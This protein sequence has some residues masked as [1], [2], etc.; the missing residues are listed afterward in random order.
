MKILQR[1]GVSGRLISSFAAIGVTLAAICVTI[2]VQGQE[3]KTSIDEITDYRVPVTIHLSNLAKQIHVSMADTQATVLSGDSSHNEHRVAVWKAISASAAGLDRLAP[4]FRHQD[5]AASWRAIRSDLDQLK[6]VQEK[7]AAIVGTVEAM[8]ANRMLND[9]LEPRLQ[10]HF[11]EATALMEAETK[12][13]D[14]TALHLRY[15]ADL[16]A[17]TAGA[18][19][20][21]RG[22]LV[23]ASPKGLK[24]FEDSWAAATRGREALEAA[25]GGLVED[26]R[27]RLPAITSLRAEMR[28]RADAI[29]AIRQSDGWNIPLQ[30]LSKEAVPLADKILNRLEGNGTGI[31]PLQ[32]ERLNASAVAIQGKWDFMARVVFA[33]LLCSLVLSLVIALL[34]TRAIVAPLAR[35]KTVFGDLS[36]GRLDITIA[37]RE[38]QDEM[39]VMARALEVFRSRLKEQ[40]LAQDQ[41]HQQAQSERAQR[42]ERLTTDFDR[43][44]SQ[45]VETVTI[46]AKQLEGTADGLSAA[47]TQTDREASNVGMVSEQASANVRAIA[48]AASELHSSISEIGHQVSTASRISENAALQAGR[49]SEVAGKL[50]LAVQKIGD[51]SNLI[52]GIAA[53]TNL[54]AL[55]ATIEAARAGEAG[56]GFA[57][58]AS[59]VKGLANQTG[60]ATGEIAKQIADV[61]EQTNIVVEAIHSIGK[62]I[63]E[64]GMISAGIS[65]AV[66]KQSS[67]TSKI[68]HN[69][70]QATAGTTE[71]SRNI[72]G[73]QQAA[74][75][76]GSASGE[77]L[78]ASKVLTEG[79]AKLKGM[80]EE[81]LG[82]V[83]AA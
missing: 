14:G 48:A 33:V 22:Y 82:A 73:V 74:G 77:V 55:N 10:K 76:T 54:L 28:Q 4:S 45:A 78:A 44:A 1:F 81:F 15:M 68:A 57:V 52:N 19:A 83:Q 53:Q 71:L 43:A 64:I 23:S 35:L 41:A 17:N 69:V 70:D 67:S 24:A 5:D 63:E 16:R 37:D 38:R 49:A 11:A 32:T 31:L 59:E 50:A 34:T 58:V 66:D 40:K 39:G 30:L 6:S 26:Q 72:V 62:V 18:A 56:K 80:I 46:A 27:A 2:F 79:S 9:E 25:A 7:I 65:S 21:L 29:L 61:Q 42:V 51:V 12:R 60:Q 3:V 13:A 8:P 20:A 47:A 36:E 75:Q